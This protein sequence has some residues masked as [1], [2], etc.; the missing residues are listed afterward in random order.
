SG[1]VPN[2]APSVPFVPPSRREWDLVFQQVFDE[3]FSPPDSV[4]SPVPVVEAPAPIESTGSPS[5]TL[6]NQDALS[7]STSQ[8]THQSQSYELG[9]ILK[10]KARLVACGYRQKEGIDFEESFALVVRLEAVLIF[11]AFAAHINMI[12]Y[13]MDVK[14]TFFN[15]M[16]REE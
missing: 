10:N 13:Q 5:S 11:F 16:L 9:G 8:S 6:V 1:L 2:P 15:G 3:L 14:T 7:P 4:A 12:V